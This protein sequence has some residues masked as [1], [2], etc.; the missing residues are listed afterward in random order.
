MRKLK[1]V[2]RETEL[3]EEQLAQEVGLLAAE[4]KTAEVRKQMLSLLTSSRHVTVDALEGALGVFFDRA[5][6]A[7]VF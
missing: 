6:S 2:L 7:G 5:S 3:D 4:L 1:T